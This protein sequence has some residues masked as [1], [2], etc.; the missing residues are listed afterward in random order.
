[1]RG[2]C[3][4]REGDGDRNEVRGFASYLWHAVQTPQPLSSIEAVVSCADHLPVF[5]QTPRGSLLSVILSAELIGMIDMPD[6]RPL[7]RACIG[8]EIAAGFSTDCVFREDSHLQSTS[9][10]L[11]V[12]GVLC[13]VLARP[14]PL[15]PHPEQ[16]LVHQIL[17][18]ASVCHHSSPEQF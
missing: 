1:M 4:A 6:V 12:D 2:V 16:R 15:H 5:S 11:P 13:N 9:R 18:T 7:L 14:V 10:R 8:R 17:V 3:S